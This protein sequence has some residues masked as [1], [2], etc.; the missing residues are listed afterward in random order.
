M[1]E[2]KIIK[3]CAPT[4]A[5]MKTAN[6][7]NYR[8]SSLQSLQE[9]V[10]ASN[11][12]LNRK[13]VY[14][15]IMRIRDSKALLYVYRR[16]R[17]EKDLMNQEAIELLSHYGYEDK[18]AD[19]AIAHLKQR[20]E[21]SDCFP[22]EIGLFLSYPIEDVIGFIEHQGRDCK[23]CGLWKVYCNEKDTMKL[24]E[25][26]KNCTSIYMRLFELGSSMLQLTMVA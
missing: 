10:F 17:L 12:T 23:C 14:I 8:F 5:G 6:L 26:F 22:H 9:E 24:F 7:F 20:L 21:E 15:E 1:L 25:T 13:G 3:H 16:M 2:A 4:L 18:T 19:A 11:E